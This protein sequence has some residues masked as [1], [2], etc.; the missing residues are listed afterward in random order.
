MKR[1]HILY[2]LIVSL[3][4]GTI[5]G[6]IIPEIK[7]IRTNSRNLYCPRNN[8]PNKLTVQ[9]SWSGT[10]LSDDNAFI[11]ELSSPTGD[12]SSPIEIGRLDK[13]NSTGNLHKGSNVLPIYIKIEFPTNT[14]GNR[15]KIRIKTSTLKQD[16]S[17]NPVAQGESEFFEAHHLGSAT[18][19]EL[20][21]L[22]SPI[23]ICPGSSSKT[24]SVTGST[25]AA[26]YIWYKDGQVIPG[27]TGESYTVTQPGRYAVDPDF[28]GCSEG[29]NYRS[30]EVVVND[31]GGAN[32]AQV[33]IK[34][35]ASQ[36]ICTGVPLTLESEIVNDSSGST[37]TYQWY[38]DNTLITGANQPTYNVTAVG[39]Y[40]VKA[41]PSTGCE[42]TSSA[43]TITQRNTEGLLVIAGGNN[44]VKCSGQTLPLTA[45][46][47]DTT[48]TGTYKWY[49]NGTVIPG[50]TT[51]SYTVSDNGSYYITLTEAGGC[52][53]KSNVVTVSDQSSVN[54]GD[55]KWLGYNNEDVVFAFPYRRP[56]IELDIPSTETL[57]IKWFKEDDP[58]NILQE[59]TTRSFQ[60]PSEGTFVAEVYDSCHNRVST[61]VLKLHVKEPSRYKPTIGFKQGS[62][63]CGGG[64]AILELSSLEATI[65]HNG[66]EKSTLVPS[67]DY[68]HYTLQW[69][70][71]GVNQSMG[72]EIAATTSN[73]LSVYRLQVNGA[74][75]SNEIKLIDIKFPTAVR[76]TTGSGAQELEDNR[77]LDL[78]PT[79]MGTFQQEL[80][81][82]KWYFRKDD[83]Q[84]WV[85][86]ADVT[87]LTDKKYTI[88][89]APYGSAA[90]RESIG[91]YQLVVRLK[92]GTVN[93]AGENIDLTPYAHSCGQ[94]E[95]LINISYTLS[96]QGKEI[97]NIVLLSGED[98]NRKWV[99]PNEWTGA[100]VTIYKQTGEIIYKSDRYNN[101]FPNFEPKSTERGAAIYY[102][103]VIEKDGKT[104]NGTLT[105]LH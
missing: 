37:Y 69:K 25:H 43:V 80:F 51:T 81:T 53:I 89:A 31:A 104:K 52:V 92:E 54:P 41:I 83:T 72:T 7:N 78:I 85:E 94:V 8:M 60:V 30:N 11:A 32:A 1:I 48:L 82:Y 35:A 6:Q 90:F 50:I 46:L 12:F 76:I 87:A 40:T 17:G 34:G 67:S 68:S 62:S 49:K 59:N 42:K 63:P 19:L 18:A 44:Q 74:F 24:I 77:S 86:K 47:T 65:V 23:E 10:L 45:S 57:T 36:Q 88:A 22:H 73:T 79:L 39:S 16:G 28:G 71:D 96:Y 56:V 20:N 13:T 3:I 100:K 103:Y 21:N 33:R 75:N 15:Y 97:P 98:L 38:K 4:G 95:G 99:L 102:F 61:G 66:Q 14:S 64:Q 55:I 5:Y 84:S 27:V 91:Q 93:I 26:S 101:D 105:V 58:T 2:I 29:G 70:K 9:F